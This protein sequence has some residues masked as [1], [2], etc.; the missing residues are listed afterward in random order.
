M[1]KKETK[2]LQIQKPFA[3]FWTFALMINMAKIN[4]ATA[5]R[6]S[7]DKTHPT[8]NLG[9]ISHKANVG[10]YPYIY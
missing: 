9:A 7:G 1:C 8:L 5:I 6:A 2:I 3:A 10:I 4:R